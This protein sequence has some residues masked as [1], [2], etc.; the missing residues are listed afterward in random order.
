MDTQSA[1]E[2]KL[3][4]AFSPQHLKIDNESHMHSGPAT[5]SHF[6][7]TMVSNTFSELSRVKRHQEVYAVLAEELA[8]NVHA[9]ALHLYAPAEWEGIDVPDSP[10]CRG[11]SK[12]EKQ[13]IS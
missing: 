6:K 12:F 1:I 3:T 10:D 11:G 4:A 8:G 7:V 2:T 9:L 13:G 5:D